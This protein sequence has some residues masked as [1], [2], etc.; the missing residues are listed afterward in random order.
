MAGIVLVGE[1]GS[2]AERLGEERRRRGMDEP[3]FT[4]DPGRFVAFLR[5]LAAAGAT[6]GILV[7]AGPGGRRALLAERVLPAIRKAQFG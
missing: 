3:A 2:E 7:L 5:D 1:T 4:G 6:W